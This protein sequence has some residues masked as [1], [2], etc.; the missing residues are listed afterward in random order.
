[1]KNKSRHI[2]E[3]KIAGTPVLTLLVEA[4][5]S[6]QARERAEKVWREL[7][8]PPEIELKKGHSLEITSLDD[9]TR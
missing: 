4:T 5:S 6:F 3:V 1:M 7:N 9:N 8:D 2:Y